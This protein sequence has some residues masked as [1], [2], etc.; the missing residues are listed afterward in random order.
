MLLGVGFGGINRGQV[1][2]INYVNINNHVLLNVIVDVR[3]PQRF[4]ECEP[5]ESRKNPHTQ[6]HGINPRQLYYFALRFIFATIKNKKH[7]G[8][9]RVQ[10]LDVSGK[11]EKK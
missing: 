9:H 5:L 3:S 7:R 4:S 8:K 1:I 11:V 2:R 6:K 10:A